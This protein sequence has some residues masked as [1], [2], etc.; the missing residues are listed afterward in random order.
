M[1]K[2]QASW[3]KFAL[4]FDRRRLGAIA[5]LLFEAIF[6]AA[7]LPPAKVREGESSAR[8]FPAAVLAPLDLRFDVVEDKTAATRAFYPYSVIPGGASTANELR[9]AVANDP[10]VRAHYSDFALAHARVERLERSQAFYV[11]YRIGTGIFWTKSPLPLRAGET[12]L[13]D[14]AHFARTRCGNRLSLAPVAPT[15]KIEPAPE[16]MEIAD[17][18]VLTAAL[19]APEEL[20]IVPPPTSAIVTPPPV[21]PA[22]PVGIYLPLPPVFPVGVGGTSLPPGIPI[23]PGPPPSPPPGSPPSSPPP[24]PPPI[25]PPPPGPPPIVAP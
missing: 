11:S 8:E 25:T 6:L 3:A 10:T 22:P 23:T 13:T 24:G 4:A 17:G 18:G 20:P 1:G 2:G 5:V 21:P 12:V 15:S 7:Q 14:G 9:N 19:E 16:A